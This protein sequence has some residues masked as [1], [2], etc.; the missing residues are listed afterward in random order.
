MY[1]VLKEVWT[2]IDSGWPT[3]TISVNVS[4]QHFKKHYKLLSFIKNL[5]KQYKINPSQVEFE[6]TES[7]YL[8][9]TDDSLEILKYLNEEGFSIALDDFGTGFS[10]LQYLLNIP[11][12]KIKI[13]KSFI[14]NISSDSKSISIVSS[15]ILLAHSLEKKVIA[16]GVE[17]REQLHLLH[18]L[19]CDEVQGYYFSK[20]IPLEEI[21][22]L[23]KSNKKFNVFGL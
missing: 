15:L 5:N 18:Q 8:K 19:K 9:E 4:A 20:P 3:I 6:V 1:L 2:Q 10:S 7:Q 13:D 12:H 11:L 22:S 21:K 17:T 14:D 16:E 23:L